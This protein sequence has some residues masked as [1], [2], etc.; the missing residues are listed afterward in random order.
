[1][2]KGEIAPY[3]QKKKKDF[4]CRH[5]K[6]RACLG[7]V[8]VESCSLHYLK[9]FLVLGRYC[10]QTLICTDKNP[11]EHTVNIIINI[12]KEMFSSRK[13]LNILLQLKNNN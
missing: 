9:C 2:G 7:K 3:K 6:T 12:A 13:E 5:I 11:T 10:L 1:M 8:K 4:Y